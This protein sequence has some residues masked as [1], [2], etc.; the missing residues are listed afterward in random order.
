MALA[1]GL[2]WKISVKT[3]MAGQKVYFLLHVWRVLD[4]AVNTTDHRF[5]QVT[6]GP[7][8]NRQFLFKFLL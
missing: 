5:W 3:R 7:L 6:I 2:L 4:Q 8:A 1:C